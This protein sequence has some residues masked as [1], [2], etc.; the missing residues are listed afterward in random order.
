MTYKQYT[1]ITADEARWKE[2]YNFFNICGHS[3]NPRSFA[4]DILE[5][6]GT[7]CPHDQAVVFF[8]DGNCK[9]VGMEL[10]NHNEKSLR[11]YLDYYAN[12]EDKEYGGFDSNRE[13][14]NQPTINVRDWNR[15]TS[16]EFI[17]H[18]IMP[19]GLKYSCGFALYDLN[20]NPRTV[21]A[22][23]RLS[24]SQFTNG[25]LYN[26]QLA[27]TMLNNLHKNFYYQGFSLGSVKQ[28]VW[29][30]AKLTAR[31]IEIVDLLSQGISPGNI[32]KILYISQSTTY[33]HIAHIYEKMGVSSQQ[34]LLVKL[35]R[36]TE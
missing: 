27:V 10:K 30:E 24:A 36:Q 14:P 22:L 21:F 20:A 6:I 11:M 16:T 29:E 35:L 13:N 3:H 34:E 2:L 28:A 7:I 18:Y 17:P 25:E 8:L 9:V 31:E 1:K 23:D 5:N 32:S 12:I 26:L 19:M 15:E 33:K 4:L